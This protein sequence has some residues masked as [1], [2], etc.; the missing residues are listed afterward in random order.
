MNVTWGTP[1]AYANA[2]TASSE[3]DKAAIQLA[4]IREEYHVEGTV[5]PEARQRVITSWN[6]CRTIG[7][8][9]DTRTPATI[10]ENASELREANERLLRAAD[11]I[12]SLL[13]VE[14]AGTGYAAALADA[15][16]YLLRLDG[17]LDVRLSFA[18]SGV[19]PGANLS[20]ASCGTNAIGTVIADRR[21]FQLLAGEHFCHFGQRFTC[22]GAPI[23]VPET[24]VVAGV[25]GITGSYRLVRSSAIE[26]VLHCALDVEEQLAAESL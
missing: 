1:S 26:M 23:F 9:P 19:V 10:L 12:L 25:L 7:I 6:R 11:P 24:R 17:E 15:S 2:V 20:E 16:G 8:D 22:T 21:A 14:L 3:L 13:A 5:R 18:N 4:R